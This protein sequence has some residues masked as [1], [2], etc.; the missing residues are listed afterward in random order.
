MGN[1][2]TKENTGKYFKAIIKKEIEL[3]DGKRYYLFEDEFGLKH[4][5][6]SKMYKHYGFIK[7]KEIN[8]RLDHINCD[9]RLFFEPENPSY[10]EGNTYNFKVKTFAKEINYLNIEETITIVVDSFGMEQKVRYCSKQNTQE[11]YIMAHVALIKKGRLF[12]VADYANSFSLKANT[13]S[14]FKIV[15][16]KKTERFGETYILVDK[17][18]NRHGLPTKYYHNYNLYKKDWFDAEIQKVSSKGFLYIEPFHPKYEIGESYQF[19]IFNKLTHKNKLYYFVEDCFGNIIKVQNN[20][21]IKPNG[22]Q[23]LCEV[24]GLKKGKPELKVAIL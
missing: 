2:Y 4:T 17:N 13:V 9:N 12:L 19:R 21:S 3:P 14:K 6:P 24:I 22:D 8:I 15:D 7:G 16:L 11:N 10:K 5:L 20:N 18:G 1:F 23:L